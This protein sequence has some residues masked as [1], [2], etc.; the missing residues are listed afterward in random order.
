M[1]LITWADCCLKWN[2]FHLQNS[3]LWI[4]FFR[5]FLS[6]GLKELMLLRVEIISLTQSKK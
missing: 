4:R 5:M 3:L 6:I 1:L 2:V